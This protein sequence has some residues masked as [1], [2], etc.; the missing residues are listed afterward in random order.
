MYKSLYVNFI[1]VSIFLIA[2]LA[3]AGEP[4]GLSAIILTLSF[5]KIYFLMVQKYHTIFG[6]A[7]DSFIVVFFTD[8]LPLLLVVFLMAIGYSNATFEVLVWYF[9]FGQA[10]SFFLGRLSSFKSQFNVHAFNIFLT[11]KHYLRYIGYTSLLAMLI[12][13]ERYIL[14]N[15]FDDNLKIVYFL[16]SQ[17]LSSLVLSLIFGYFIVQKYSEIRLKS[18]NEARAIIFKALIF[19]GA[20]VL[21]AMIAIS[22]LSAFSF[23]ILFIEYYAQHDE[24]FFTTIFFANLLV[25]FIGFLNIFLEKFNDLAKLY[26]ITFAMYISVAM[27]AVIATSIEHYVILTVIAE[28]C[29]V[30]FVLLTVLQ[31]IK[32]KMK[33]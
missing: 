16:L 22:T 25:T 27:A 17:K 14:L 11:I 20:Y 28:F 7:E 12:T 23:K 30:V 18:G 2:W 21:V 8:S 1:I 19:I 6:K 9:C 29:L 3:I 33:I 15:I 31:S 24:V 10:F 32:N 13:F 4:Y 5:Q 26:F